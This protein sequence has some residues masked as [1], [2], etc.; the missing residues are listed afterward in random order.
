MARSESNQQSI[1]RLQTAVDALEAFVASGGK[2]N[3]GNLK[4]YAADSAALQEL[5]TENTELKRN[6]ERIKK[7]LDRV[8]SKI[9]RH[10]EEV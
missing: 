3:S 1:E 9:Q 5:R 7:R 4:D 10:V 6:Q 8:I 2:V